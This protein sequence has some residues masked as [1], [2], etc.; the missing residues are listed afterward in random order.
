MDELDAIKSMHK[1]KRR[2][3]LASMLSFIVILIVSSFIFVVIPREFS[4]IFI[5]VLMILSMLSIG[6]L[7]FLDRVSFQLNKK[8][9]KQG[10]MHEYLF[11]HS[12]PEDIHKD[13]DIVVEL[14]RDRRAA[15][16]KK[17]KI[18]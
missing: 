17:K 7:V 18:I 10:I 13:A 1:E 6:G 12:K 2:W 8:F 9:F 11:T 15:T 4:G 5:Q 14:V 16:Q 3:R